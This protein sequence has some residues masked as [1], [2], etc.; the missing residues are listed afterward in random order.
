VGEVGASQPQTRSLLRI[1]YFEMHRRKGGKEQLFSF[2]YAPQ[3]RNEY[4]RIIVSRG[5][6]LNTTR[7]SNIS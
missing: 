4:Y 2:S 7:F 5:G 3:P 6:F 1:F